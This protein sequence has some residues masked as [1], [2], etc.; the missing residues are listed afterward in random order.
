LEEVTPGMVIKW[1]KVDE[2]GKPLFSS[3]GTASEKFGHI[4]E[5]LKETDLTHERLGGLRKEVSI[6]IAEYADTS[7]GETFGGYFKNKDANE[8]TVKSG[9]YVNII[10]NSELVENAAPN[11]DQYAKVPMPPRGGRNRATIFD[12]SF[13]KTG[14]LGSGQKNPRQSKS[15]VSHND[16]ESSQEATP[17]MIPGLAK[18]S[19]VDTVELTNQSGL[20]REK[21]PESTVRERLRGPRKT[22]APGRSLGG[23]RATM[24]HEDLSGEKS[25]EMVSPIARRGTFNRNNATIAV[26]DVRKSPGF[27]LANSN[28]KVGTENASAIYAPNVNFFLVSKN[29]NFCR[30]DPAVRFMTTSDR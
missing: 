11:I 15:G 3:L 26:S 27:G 2:K 4:R 20:L 28:V 29:N 10:E 8:N 21:S 30:A 5:L 12:T 22:I 16:L 9:H 13:A 6:K 18:L 14:F 23:K 17:L 1:K 19:R 7:Y 24:R 25:M